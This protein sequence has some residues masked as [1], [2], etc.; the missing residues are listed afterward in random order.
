MGGGLKAGSQGKGGAVVIEPARGPLSMTS[1][2][3]GELVDNVIIPN[4]P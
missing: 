2:L 4:V 1:A 3:G